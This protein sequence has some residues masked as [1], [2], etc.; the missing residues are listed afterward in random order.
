MPAHETIIV[1]LARYAARNRLGGLACLAL[2][3]ACE[4]APAPAVPSEVFRRV[5]ASFCT[6]ALDCANRPAGFVFETQRECEDIMLNSI[7]GAGA[8]VNYDTAAAN[9]RVIW[10]NDDGD[11]CAELA[12]AWAA[13]ATCQQLW[14]TRITL[15][16]SDPRCDELGQGT[17]AAGDA[18]AVSIE[19]AEDN[20]CRSGTCEP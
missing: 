13:S 17:V 18:C 2:L 1:T 16:Y 5:I 10:S 20:S 4:S 14:A 8:M 7:G 15:N 11:Y 19:C 6:H 12:A 3:A 9:D